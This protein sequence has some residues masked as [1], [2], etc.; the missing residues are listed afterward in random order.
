MHVVVVSV[1]YKTA[2]VAMREKLAFKDNE[3]ENALVT[4]SNKKSIL[5][6]VILSTCN[7]TEVYAV[8]D[9]LHTGKY[10][11]QS[12]LADWFEQSLDT[13]KEY[14]NVLNENDAIEHLFKVTSGLDS[15][16]LGETQILGQM[17]DAFQIAQEEV[18]TGTMF[19]RLFKQAITLAKRAHHETDIASNA[20]SVSYAAVELS[21]KVLGRLDNKKALIIGAGEMAEL[22]VAN[23]NGSGVTDITVI[24]RTAAK[25][26]S[27]A[28]QYSGVAK[29]I[30]ELQCSLMEAD[31]V[32]SST[33]AD[34][35]ILTKEMMN[36]VERFRRNK[37]LVLIDIAVPRDIDPAVNELELMY[38]YDVD[39]LNG[40]VDANLGEREKAARE[41]E[42]LIAKEID[43][44]EEWVNMLGVVPVISALRDKASHIQQDTMVSIERKLPDMTDRER[45]VISK[46]MKSIVNQ[47][48]K[49]PITQAKELSTDKKSK[50]KLELFQEIFNITEEVERFNET[51]KEKNKV[52]LQA[53][54]IEP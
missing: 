12:F 9:Q 45:K 15:M 29:S 21:K 25:A 5:E 3:I 10:Y 28:M 22:A 39:D 13:I 6:C 33:S 26:E 40:L 36:D 54:T 47:L 18:T 1:N 51:K 30:N 35:Y 11:I 24:N 2:D 19:N 7:R 43:K 48:L 44:H 16:V 37:P 8:V 4:L 17:K 50:E 27:L 46:H 38:N 31:I 14:T 34:Q 49:D 52:Q 41:I 32:I 20:V 53:S 42:L 23:L